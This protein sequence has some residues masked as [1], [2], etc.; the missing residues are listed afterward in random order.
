MLYVVA[1]VHV[2]KASVVHRCCCCCC[3][4]IY[5][6]IVLVVS[7]IAYAL[8]CS[9]VLLD[10]CCWLLCARHANGSSQHQPHSRRNSTIISQLLHVSQRFWCI[11][12]GDPFWHIVHFV[13][14]L[15]KFCGWLLLGLLCGMRCGFGMYFCTSTHMYGNNGCLVDYK[16]HLHYKSLVKFPN[17]ILAVLLLIL[18]HLLALYFQLF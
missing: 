9:V 11:R 16:W 15:Y 7:A 8:C 14:V 12:L 13:R 6:H 2:A 5:A 4:H 18:M 3:C 1:K 17:W 10:G